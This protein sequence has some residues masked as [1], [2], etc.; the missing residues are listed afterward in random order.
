MSLPRRLL[1]LLLVIPTA[2]ACSSSPAADAAPNGADGVAPLMSESTDCGSAADTVR[3]HVQSD[4]IESVTVLGQCTLVVI[5]TSLA[6]EDD[7]TAREICESAAEVAYTGDINAVSV[8]SGTGEE[9][10]QGISGAR[11]IP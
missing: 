9:L 11:C 8:K 7:A 6:D 1:G 10:S 4:K 5:G 2:A 3:Q